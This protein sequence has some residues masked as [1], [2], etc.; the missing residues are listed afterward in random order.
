[1]KNIFLDFNETKLA[2]SLSKLAK[3]NFW[4]MKSVMLTLN[5]KKIV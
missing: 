3:K 2:N 5:E 1:M 4:K